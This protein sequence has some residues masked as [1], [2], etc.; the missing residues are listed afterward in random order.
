MPGDETELAEVHVV[1]WQGAYR[2]QVPAAHLEALSILE[3]KERWAAILAGAGPSEA[4]FVAE[5]EGRIVGF[6]HCGPARDDDAGTDVGELYS[7]YL[8]PGHIGSGL[9]RALLERATGALRAA[10]FLGATLWVFEANA[11]ARRFYEAAG[12]SFDGRQAA[13]ALGGATLSELR[14]RRTL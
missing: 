1:S 13:F 10:G 4:A 14:S 2:G 11:R 8:L 9:G 5:L 6:A 3:H 12:W 7:I